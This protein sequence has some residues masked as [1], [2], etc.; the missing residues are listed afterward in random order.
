MPRS[1]DLAIL[2]VTDIDDGR[3]TKPITLFTPC[4]CAGVTK[5]CWRNPP[6][7][8][9]DNIIPA[10]CEFCKLSNQQCTTG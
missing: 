7:I 3:Q 1:R 8:A 10:Y 4:A 9:L 6:H 5:H 2:A